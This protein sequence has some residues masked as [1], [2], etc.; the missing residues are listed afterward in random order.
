MA[1]SHRR[2]DAITLTATAVTYSMVW[3]YAA[4]AQQAERVHRVGVLV[5]VAGSVVQPLVAAFREGLANLGW[6]EGRN[7]RIDYRFSQGDPGRP[8]AY[9]EEL[10]K[11]QPDLVFAFSGPATRAVQQ[12][13]SVIPIV[14]AGG[15]DP[16]SIGLVGNIARPAGNVTGFANVFTTLGGK[17][18]E[19]FKEAV[20]RLA[21]LADVFT[22]NEFTNPQNELRATID[23]AAAQLGLTI[24]RMPLR[25][26]E[27]IEPAISTFAAEPDGGLLA[28]IST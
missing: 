15:G 2:R 14:F 28:W 24:V 7:L 18:L 12:R 21:R 13:T 20:P 11:L 10:V 16:A 26:P 9:A 23:A 25:N 8:D 17:W 3:P 4:L 27:E 22:A 19:L 6:V 5:G 1:N